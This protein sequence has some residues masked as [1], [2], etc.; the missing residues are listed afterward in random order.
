[1]ENQ[2]VQ[3]TLAKAMEA[4]KRVIEELKTAR[5]SLVHSGMDIKEVNNT[6]RKAHAEASQVEVIDLNNPNL[7]QNLEEYVPDEYAVTELLSI[8]HGEAVQAIV[9]K[10]PELDQELPVQKGWY[11]RQA[12]SGIH[13][14]GGY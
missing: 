6:I 12:N 7:P 4:S 11:R 9:K 8:P 2:D 1:M 14:Y 10:E 5:K 13:R 3:A